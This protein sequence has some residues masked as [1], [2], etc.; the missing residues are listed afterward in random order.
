MEYWSIEGGRPLGGTAKIHG[1][2]NAV[3]PIMAASLLVD[4]A[5]LY[6]CPVL[7]DV[8]AAARILRALG[9]TVTRCGE[10]LTVLNTE[11]V[12]CETLPEEPAREMRS[13]IL[14][15]G[16][17]L[18]RCGRARLSFPGG[19]ELG[20]RPIDLH[21][22]GLARLGAEIREDGGFLD[23]RV[24]GRLR[25]TQIALPFPSVGA[26][27]NLLLA[28][29]TAE[30]ET[31]VTNAAREPEVTALAEFLNTCGADIVC[32][33]DRIRVRGVGELHGCAF[34]IPP[35]RI[36]AATYLCAAAATGGEIRVEG[37]CPA[38]L[39]AVLPFFEEMGCRLDVGE[40][41]IELAAPRCLSGV[42]CVRT[43]PY[44]GFPTDAQA[45]LMAALCR[46]EGST[47]FIETIFSARYRHVGELLRMGACISTD[48]RTALVR[49]VGRL[50]GAGVACTDLRGG[51]ALVVAALAAEGETRLC[52]THHIERGYSDFVPLL[53]AL[54]AEITILRQEEPHFV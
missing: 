38:H 18:A 22:M 23:C 5:V 45:P 42:G 8:D 9:C 35:D 13:S 4:R 48:G 1:A 54:G 49:G 25:G 29:A 27:E 50:H 44:P 36:E 21:L 53:S 31:I 33:G 6:R 10:T 28:A 46:S 11:G 24:N 15:L 7:T 19:C 30:G 51:A 52:E 16:A 34:A 40:D 17:L 26:T 12:C 37:V 3:L 14:F 2:K 32:D 41:T 39:A 20:P 47:L 43:M